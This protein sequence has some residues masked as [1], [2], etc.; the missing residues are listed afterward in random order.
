MS[1]KSEKDL[2]GSVDQ[3]VKQIA[4]LIVSGLLRTRTKDLQGS[5]FS[6]EVGVDN[7]SETRVYGHH[8]ESPGGRM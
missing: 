1:N 4:D 5:G 6:A 3:R 2:L 7:T 8:S